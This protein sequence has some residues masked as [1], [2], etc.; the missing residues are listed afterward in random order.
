MV[1]GGGDTT[2]LAATCFEDQ[3]EVCM[4][5]GIATSTQKVYNC[6]HWLFL[7]FCSRLNRV[8]P[9]ASKATIV[10]FVTELAQSRAQTTIKSYLSGVRHLHIT[11]GFPNLLECCHWLDL[12]LKGI[13]RTKP[14]APGQEQLPITPSILLTIKAGLEKLSMPLI[15]R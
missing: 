9:P 5:N 7:D 12:I 10:I 3:A 1:P 14:R 13:K 11:Q 2:R 15:R 8:P 4:K 6:A